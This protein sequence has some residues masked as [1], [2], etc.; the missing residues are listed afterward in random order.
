MSVIYTLEPTGQVSSRPETLSMKHFLVSTQ[1][2]EGSPVITRFKRMLCK[3]CVLL[4]PT[5]NVT[6]TAVCICIHFHL[7]HEDK[8]NVRWIFFWVALDDCMFLTMKPVIWSL[9]FISSKINSNSSDQMWFN[10][11]RGSVLFIDCLFCYLMKLR[12]MVV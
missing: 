6:L 4:F 12:R 10:V 3:E 7:S 9:A 11:V 8:L 2:P 1:L 5:V